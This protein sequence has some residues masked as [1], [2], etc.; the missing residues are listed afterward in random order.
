MSWLLFVDESGH[1]HKSCPYEIRGGI[2]LHAGKLWPF[3]QAMKRLELSC[4]GFHLHEYKAELK[5]STLVD[6]KRFGFARQVSH[7][8]DNL[9]RK[10]CRSFFT[11]N[12]ERKKPI[13]NEFAA[14]GRAC[15]EMARGIFQL[16]ADHEAVL[17]AIATH[18]KS[19]RGKKTVPRE[20]FLR[21]DQVFL[22]ER[23]FYFLELKK[24]HGLLI[25]DEVEKIADRKFVSQLEAYF[26]K[27]KTGLHRTQWIV[28][29]PFFVSSD[30]IYPMQ[31]TDLAIYCVNWGFRLPKQGMDENV[32]KEVAEEFG[33]WLSRL[34]FKGDGYRDGEVFKSFGI[35]FVSNPYGSSK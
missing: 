2:A 24:E 14:Y 5:G 6:K 13:E 1:D 26:T 31:A 3:V 22:L 32:R 10:L 29:S 19:H 33:P 16:L 25:V 34:Q 11:K 4:F 8:D 28:P 18:P 35:G 27:T 7:M 17:F 30:M 15:L 21:K 9:R 23:F 12:S 20:E